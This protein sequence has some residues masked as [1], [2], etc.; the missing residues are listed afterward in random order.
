M[1]H[2]DG[3][4]DV[5]K[6]QIINLRIYIIK[7]E[8]H[9]AQRGGELFDLTNFFFLPLWPKSMEEKRYAEL[10]PEL[11]ERMSNLIPCKR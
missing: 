9:S 5:G 6:L 8:F 7:D 4:D 3:D 11:Y 10:L 1:E 2:G